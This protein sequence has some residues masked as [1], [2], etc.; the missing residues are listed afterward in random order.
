MLVQVFHLCK[1]ISN[2]VLEKSSACCHVVFRQCLADGCQGFLRVYLS[3]SKESA[4]SLE[5]IVFVFLVY[6]DVL[7]LLEG[8]RS[9]PL[10]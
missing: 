10:L 8:V 2:L 5:Q 4:I 1:Y 7:Q 3:Q 6:Q 9:G